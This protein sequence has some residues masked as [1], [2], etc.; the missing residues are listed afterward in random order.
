MTRE[1]TKK[2][3]L[4]W[5]HWVKACRDKLGFSRKQLAQ[6]M[7][8]DVSYIWMMETRGYV[9]RP[10]IVMR[11]AKE[12]QQ[13]KDTAWLKAYWQSDTMTCDEVVK[14]LT[15]YKTREVK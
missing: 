6:A 1:K 9:P 15:M 4:E 13:D 7:H 12:L 14:V 2:Y 3:K 10:P 11:L 8:I 5:G